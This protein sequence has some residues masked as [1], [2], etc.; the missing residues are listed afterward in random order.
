MTDK[1]RR[2]IRLPG[3]DY[4][5]SGA[6]F[7][8][9]VTAERKSLFGTIDGVDLLLNQT[10]RIAG[11]EWLR[12]EKRFPYVNIEPYVVMPNHIHGILRINRIDATHLG[13][14]LEAFGKPVPGS[15]PTVIRSYKSSVTVRLQHLLHRKVAVWQ[16]GYYEHIVRDEVDWHRIAGYIAANAENW[17]EDEEFQDRK[18]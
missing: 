14:S 16:R 10:G 12:L 3:Y 2:S 4:T 9:L 11:D 5:L 13:G 18:R 1:H 7:I 15:I 6:Y 17:F 8:T